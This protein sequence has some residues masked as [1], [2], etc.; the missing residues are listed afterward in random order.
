MHPGL[1]TYRGPSPREARQGTAAVTAPY[2]QTTFPLPAQPEPS[3]PAMPLES[4]RS[5]YLL[6][7]M[8]PQDGSSGGRLLTPF[9]QGFIYW[10]TL[11][12]K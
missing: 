8:L 10:K 1:L 4:C 9:L 5:S 7:G 11:L 3:A 12:T 6:R 2:I